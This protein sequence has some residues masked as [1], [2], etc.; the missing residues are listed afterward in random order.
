MPSLAPI[1]I[2][3]NGVDQFSN[4][5]AK[6][7]KGLKKTADSYVK[8]GRTATAALTLPIAAAA[9][10]SIK[11]TMDINKSMAN[12]ASLIPGNIDRVNALKTSLQDLSVT[13]GKATTDLADGTYQ[14]ISALGDTADTMKIVDI[15]ARAATAGVSTTEDAVNLL[16]AITKGYGD[17]TAAATKKVADLSFMTVKLGKTSFPELAASMGKSVPIANAL[18]I[19]QEELFTAF[20][21]LTGVTGTTS[22]VSTQ[23]VSVM[24]AMLKPSGELTKTVQSMGFASASAMM[25]EEGLVESLKLLN[26]AVGGNADYMSRLLG[27][28]EALTAAL[29]L[30]GSQSDV[31][32]K[33]LGE[34]KNATGA[35]STAFDA[36][37]KGINKA[38]FATQQALQRMSVAG[39]RMGDVLLPVVA[40][41]AELAS[42]V[43]EKVVKIPKPMLA[44]IAAI[45]GIVAAAGPLLMLVGG[46]ISAFATVTGAIA[47]AGGAVA[48]LSNPIGWA[49]V[50]VV[51]LTAGVVYLWKKMDSFRGL[52]ITVKNTLVNLYVTLKPLLKLFAYLGKILIGLPLKVVLF[53]LESMFKVLEKML[54]PLNWVLSKTAKLSQGF[55]ESPTGTM[56][57]V[58]ESVMSN[59][60]KIDLS[61]LSN[62]KQEASKV[63]IDFLNP[64]EGMKVTQEKG[65]VEMNSNNGAIMGGAF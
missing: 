27:R 56:E 12:V 31:F 18:K 17:T 50:G 1:R 49:V 47:G 2:V 53:Q 36:Q 38:G 45:G 13:T 51:S 63:V 29:A 64:P 23:L 20:A 5:F 52:I 54:K 24:G 22:E 58:K 33:K 43:F 21:T 25:K 30:T 60:N 42:K 55:A 59:I 6:L 48:L 15:S 62:V 35:M 65:N 4:K 41:L 9:A 40:K 11:S 3:I 16:T 39:Q 8:V 46:L 10:A 32:T 14:V 57:S 19:S 7:N 44:T 28:K 34:M 61:A 26:K 37:T